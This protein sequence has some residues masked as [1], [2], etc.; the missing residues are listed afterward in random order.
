MELQIKTAA[1]AQEFAAEANDPAIRLFTVKRHI[2]QEPVKDVDGNW[3]ICS[4]QT[5]PTFS[6]VLYQ[7]GLNLHK[8]L[9]TPMGLI[10]SS[11]GGTPIQAWTPAEGFTEEDAATMRKTLGDH[12]KYPSAPSVLY[13]G[14]IAP[15]SGYAPVAY[16]IWYQGEADNSAHAGSRLWPAHANHDRALALRLEGRRLSLLLRADRALRR[17]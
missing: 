2:A 6:A 8:K 12:P 17:L 5:L 4:P 16:A 3:E 11:W 14:M 9:H 10:H 15:I 7:F 13:N 1:R